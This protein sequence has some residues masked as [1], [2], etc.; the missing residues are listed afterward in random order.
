MAKCRAL[1]FSIPA[2]TWAPRLSNCW[3]QS[4]L[5]ELAAQCSGVTFFILS[6]WL[7]CAPWS[8]K[9]FETPWFPSEQAKCSAV[10]PKQS[11]VFASAY[12][13]FNSFPT[14]SLRPINIAI[15]S[16][17][18]VSSEPG[19][20]T[21]WKLQFCVYFPNIYINLT[22]LATQ[23]YHLILLWSPCLISNQ[24]LEV[25]WEF[26]LCHDSARFPDRVSDIAYGIVAFQRLIPHHYFRWK[27]FAFRHL[28]HRLSW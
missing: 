27:C 9:V 11:T 20:N 28:H 1:L 22:A 7:T 10:R 23:T 15:I 26:C 5:P 13:S 14:S 17:V 12:S 8:N 19:L 6:H 24:N 16:A 3:I 21:N 2:L 25:L 4:T 18:F